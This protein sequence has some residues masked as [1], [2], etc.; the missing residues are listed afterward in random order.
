M[1]FD[2]FKELCEKRGI[3]VK[4]AAEDIGLSNSIATKWKNTGATPSGT[5][6]GI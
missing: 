4:R 5:K 2:I 1:F 3:S 6:C